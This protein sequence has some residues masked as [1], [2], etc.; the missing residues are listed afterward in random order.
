MTLCILM[1]ISLLW[2]ISLL[3]AVGND[4]SVS[5][6]KR[7]STDAIFYSWNVTAISPAN[8]R[9][10]EN[11]LSVGHDYGNPCLSDPGP[12]P[13]QTT[14]MLDFLYSRS[15]Q[16][17]YTESNH[18]LDSRP[19]SETFFVDDNSAKESFS[20]QWKGQASPSPTFSSVPGTPAFTMAPSITKCVTTWTTHLSARSTSQPRG[21]YP[22]VTL[23]SQRP[24][25]MRSPS[26]RVLIEMKRTW[27][28]HF[29]IGHLSMRITSLTII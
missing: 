22:P 5:S 11:S 8:S 28:R 3:M 4:P 14:S 29:N 27:G 2:T 24:S 6:I 15:N 1:T 13:D 9:N 26:S 23:Q 25:P 18:I 21:A 20:D 10:D 7:Q 12:G 16:V 17:N 19:E